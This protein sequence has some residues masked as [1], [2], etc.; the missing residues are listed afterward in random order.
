MKDINIGII[1]AGKMGE[2]HIKVLLEMEGVNV[3]GF[4]EPNL[5]RAHD[6]KEKYSIRH[7]YGDYENAFFSMCD[8]VDVCCATSNHVEMCERAIDAACDVFVE[9]PIA[10]TLKEALKL[11]EKALK[12]K[13]VLNVGHIENFNPA[14][15]YLKKNIKNPTYIKFSRLAP[16][17][18]RGADVDVCYD[19]TIHDIG[20]ML[21]LVDSKIKKI[22]SIKT[23]LILNS[24]GSDI[25]HA[26]ISFENGC[27]VEFETSRVSHARSR[28]ITVWDSTGEWGVDLE[29]KGAIIEVEDPIVKEKT[30]D[31]KNTNQLED[32][33]RSFFEEMYG[34]K[35]GHAPL[36]EN[37]NMAVE[38]LRIAEEIVN[39]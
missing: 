6:I 30:L 7:F 19:L 11:R 16:F 29:G 31:F 12:N 10:P 22:E 15:L 23:K 24:S 34:Y 26:K 2:N 21:E 35:E 4:I 14:F 25:I 20:M 39:A 27:V 8:A 38:S 36:Q 3:V 28:E 32:E 5:G 9:K 37:V 33:L 13:S 17:T 18:Q 1:G